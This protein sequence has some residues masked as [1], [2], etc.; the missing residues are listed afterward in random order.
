MQTCI[1]AADHD[2]DP[3]VLRIVG[4]L[5]TLAVERLDLDVTRLLAL[6]PKRLLIDLS[7][8]TFISS[9]GIGQLLMLCGHVAGCG[10]VCVIVADHPTVREALARCRVEALAPIWNTAPLA[11]ESLSRL[12]G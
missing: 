5:D 4:F 7:G 1:I 6:R 8:L 10:G 12:A 11:V 3:V 2:A 9:L